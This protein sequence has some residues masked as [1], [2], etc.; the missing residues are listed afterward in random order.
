MLRPRGSQIYNSKG[1]D[2]KVP[3]RVDVK[4]AGTGGCVGVGVGA[5]LRAAGTHPQDAHTLKTAFRTS[6]EK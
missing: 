2:F 5:P 6:V 4:V 3:G 1:S